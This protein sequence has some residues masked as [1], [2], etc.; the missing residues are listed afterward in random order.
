MENVI[1]FVKDNIETAMS[2]R[3]VDSKIK[4]A[5]GLQHFLSL[6]PFRGVEQKYYEN[7]LSS[8]IVA[9]KYA[10]GAGLIFLQ[11]ITG[12][13][14]NSEKALE[15]K[16]KKQLIECLQRLN[17]ED[18]IRN[19]LIFSLDITN[20]NTIFQIKK[21]NTTK[22]YVEY[23]EGH[24]FDINCLFELKGTFRLE[25][26]KVICVDGYIENVG[27]IHRILH[28]AFESKTD[29]VLACRGMSDDV[30]HTLKVNFDRNT[31][32][33]IPYVVP[34]DLDACNTLVDIAVSTGN[35]VVSS[36]KGQ[37]ISSINI[38]EIRSS[39]TCECSTGH[40][41][42]FD[43]NNKISIDKHVKN[44]SKKLEE[45]PELEKHLLHRLRSLN[46]SCLEFHIP[47]DMSYEFRSQ[48]LDE[49]IRMLSSV[50][51]KKKS[52]REIVEM[53]Y[54]S[55]SESLRTMTFTDIEN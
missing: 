52:T 45:Q 32:R 18:C 4:L 3:E 15:P 26:P 7:I 5:K 38:S 33:V 14:E 36:L 35:D 41:V 49:G 1:K 46:S 50:L 39:N 11:K 23:V 53:L 17:L 40:V 44:L 16:N 54:T 51:Q 27:E 31:L 37:L 22:M 8:A 29:C 6:R 12:F 28:D 55:Y 9:E 47:G 20:S 25:N 24:R 19:M 43:K 48:Q 10:S 42:I 2:L 13:K 34:F 21:S 30:R